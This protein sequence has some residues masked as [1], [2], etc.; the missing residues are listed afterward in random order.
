VF[1]SCFVAVALESTMTKFLTGQGIKD[2][3]AMKEKTLP[4]LISLCL[5]GTKEN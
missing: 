4:I 5:H 1:F 3:Q 2:L